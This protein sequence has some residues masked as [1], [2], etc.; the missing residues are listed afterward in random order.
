MEVTALF[1]LL[2][3][4]FT[5]L[6]SHTLKSDA[7]FLRITPN[8][9]QHFKSDSVSFDCVGSDASTKLR[10]FRESKE[11]DPACDIKSPTG[12]SCTIERIYPSDSGE[13][14]C[15]T[16]GGERSNSANITVT[17]G[18][19]ILESPV[20]PVM[21]GDSVT[22]SC[23]TKTN[24]TN[25]QADFFKDGR[26][27]M[28]S[29]AEKTIKSVSKSDEGL[30]RCSISGGGGSPE[31]WLAVREPHSKAPNPPKVLFLLWIAVTVLMLALVL[32]L[33]GFLHIRNR[34]VWAVEDA[35]DN[36]DS[37]TR[38]RLS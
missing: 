26:L 12:S 1:T 18:P 4:E 11:I 25:L 34:R 35:A 5:L 22:L 13:Y 33:M 27:I 20:L 31:S 30:Y 3:L 14:W 28:E 9:L 16:G 24:F 17:D 2:L 29:S 15:E 19:V 23:R 8:R 21:D 36:P 6:N 10:V 32:L 37:V 7:A 38:C